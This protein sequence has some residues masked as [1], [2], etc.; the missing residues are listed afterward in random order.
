MFGVNDTDPDFARRFFNMIMA[1]TG[2]ERFMMGISS[3]DAAREIVLASLPKD[4]PQNELN[5]KLFER[6]YGASIE[7][8]VKQTRDGED[9]P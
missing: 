1:R 8:I 6:I 7:Q 3:F 5:R 9:L 4:L 2:E